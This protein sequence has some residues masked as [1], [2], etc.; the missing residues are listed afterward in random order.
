V[1]GIIGMSLHVQTSIIHLSYKLNAFLLLEGTL[2]RASVPVP[3]H[4]NKRAKTQ[5]CEGTHNLGVRANGLKSPSCVLSRLWH[6]EKLPGHGTCKGY[7]QK[8]NR[9][10]LE[11]PLD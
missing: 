10:G 6:E 11:V 4:M 9:Q 3:L 8:Y 5:N 2:A 1:V 7:V